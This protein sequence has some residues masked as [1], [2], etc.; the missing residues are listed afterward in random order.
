MCGGSGGSDES[1]RVMSKETFISLWSTQNNKILIGDEHGM[2]RYPHGI[3]NAERQRMTA[4]LNEYAANS[5]EARNA[6]DKAIKEGKIISPDRLSRL[7]SSAQGHPD[8][9][10]A[11]AAQRILNKMGKKW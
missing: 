7:T 5:K 8:N 6:Y 11:K 9:E 4:R 3:S 1:P 10:S 2:N